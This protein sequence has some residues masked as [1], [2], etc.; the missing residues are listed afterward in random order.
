[1]LN[2][3]TGRRCGGSESQ[4]VSRQ[5]DWAQT[6]ADT[7]PSVAQRVTTLPVPSLTAALDHLDAIDLCAFRVAPRGRRCRRWPQ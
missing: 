2:P 7:S 5:L 3:R 6:T 1:M 4:S